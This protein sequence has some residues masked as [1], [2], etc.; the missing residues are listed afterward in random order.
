[1][2]HAT[3]AAPQT[4]PRRRIAV[5]GAGISGLAA[6][7]CLLE[8]GLD[9]VVFEQAP[10]AGGIWGAGGEASLLYPSLRT[11]T[12]KYNFAYSGLPFPDAA[13][14]FP[15]WSEVNEYLQQYVGHAGLQ[16]YLRCNTTVEAIEPAADGQWSVRARAGE[17]TWTEVFDG[18]VVC[19][20]RN[21]TPFVP[22]FPGAERFDGSISHSSGYR[23]P[24]AF[25]GQTVVV[26][27]VGSSGVD[28][29]TEVSRVARR[30]YLSMSP[31]TWFVPRYILSRPYDFLLTRLATQLPIALQNR[32]FRSLVLGA[33]RRA[34]VTVKR[35]RASGV[36]L[37]RFDLYRA[38]F[39]PCNP[40]LLQQ[41]AAGAILGKP[42]VAGL[43]P[44]TVV[45]ADGSRV[46]ADTL[47]CCTGYQLE[48][49][50]LA[51]SLLEIRQGRIDLY[52]HIFPPRLPNLAF[53]GLVS[54]A[55]SH[56]PVAEMQARWVAQV[57]AGV[58]ALPSPGA[59]EADI[60]RQL[61]HPRSQNPIPMWVQIPN[62]PD[63]LAHMLGVYPHPWRHAR[64]AARLLLGPLSADD[65][66][67]EQP[68][69]RWR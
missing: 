65:Y 18:V 19:A 67:L 33:Y 37:P 43:A 63:R 6:A 3:P 4:M 54:V 8:E 17:T 10:Q 21:H 20:G 28:V 56:P 49:P 23:G 68:K 27:G 16:P 35:L 30:V 5:I 60:Q 48:Y 44:H 64:H 9:P 12:S 7:R 22:E 62:Y 45:F 32:F 61:A 47:L 11:N 51:P 25:A 69:T 36:T 58:R 59:M 42:P 53:V 26:V 13:P 57:F 52:H 46:T 1:V 14:D 15:S 38:R 34:G 41:I 29:A 39:T 24:E 50:F 2:R 55:G 40:E 66:R 31:R